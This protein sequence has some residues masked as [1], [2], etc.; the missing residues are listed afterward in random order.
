MSRSFIAKRDRAMRLSFCCCTAFRP[1]SVAYPA[2][3]NSGAAILERGRC[4]GTTFSIGAKLFRGVGLACRQLP[5]RPDKVAGI[6][7]RI[8]LQI[9]LMLGLGFPERTCRGDLGNHLAR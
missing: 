6:A 8:A 9:I 5:V 7:V 4:A 3:K 1:P 2:Q